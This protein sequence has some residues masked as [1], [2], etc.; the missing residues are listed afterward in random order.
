MIV[1]VPIH[2]DT[3][4]LLNDFDYA[5]SSGISSIFSG[6][7]VH[8]GFQEQFRTVTFQPRSPEMDVGAILDSMMGGMQ[9]D[10]VSVL[11]DWLD[12]S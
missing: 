4:V 1:C 5:L 6:I 12:D 10:R 9:P 8:R 2:Q 11:C 7:K 3:K